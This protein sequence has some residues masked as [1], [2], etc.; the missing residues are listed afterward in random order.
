MNEWDN[1]FSPDEQT[2]RAVVVRQFPE[3]DTAEMRPLGEGFD[4]LAFKAG[5]WVF[6]FPRRPFGVRTLTTESIVLPQLG[7]EVLVGKP[8]PEF[9][10]PFLGT[11]FQSGVPLVEYEGPRTKL[12]GMLGAELARIHSLPVPAGTPQDPVGKFEMPRRLKQIE[13]RLG[14]IP[15]WAP[16]TPP[17]DLEV[18]VHGDVHCRHVFVSPQGELEGLIDW[19]DL[20]TGHPAI[21][22]ACAWAYFEPEDRKELWRAYGGVSE[23]TLLYSRF[24]A[25]YHT[26]LLRDY[27]QD[28]GLIEVL[29]ESV[30][31][32]GRILD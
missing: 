25:L 12:A 20:S 26:L 16:T 15:S 9:P 6:R 11:R 7:L 13:E 30:A 3:I 4:C 32:L 17:G 8:E 5:S 23:E 2:A 21:D 27:A 22:L 14:H 29:K 31:G 19:G 18:F 24:R 28:Q 10:Y 1:V